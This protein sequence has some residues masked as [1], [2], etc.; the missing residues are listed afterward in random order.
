MRM[1]SRINIRVHL[2]FIRTI[3]IN[4]RNLVILNPAV[5]QLCPVTGNHVSSENLK[6]TNVITET[7]IKHN[8]NIF[9]VSEN[10]CKIE[11]LESH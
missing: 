8:S 7:E 4:E 10:L 1:N 2:T 9:M 6:N 3:R 5:Q 11:T